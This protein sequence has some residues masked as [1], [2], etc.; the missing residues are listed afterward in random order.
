MLYIFLVIPFI[1][2]V[3]CQMLWNWP[4]FTIDKR[5]CNVNPLIVNNINSDSSSDSS[6]D[7]D[8]DNYNN[9]KKDNVIFEIS[10]DDS[11]K[12]ANSNYYFPYKINGFM[13]YSKTGVK[14]VE[15]F[16]TWLNDTTNVSKN[17]QS[18]PLNTTI[19]N[20]QNDTPINN[21]QPIDFNM[22]NRL[23]ELLHSMYKQDFMWSILS[24]TTT[25][26]LSV[27]FTTPPC[28][29]FDNYYYT[30]NTNETSNADTN[31]DT[32]A[33][34]IID[35][36]SY[37]AIADQWMRLIEGIFVKIVKTDLCIIE[38]LRSKEHKTAFVVNTLIP[39][40][41]KYKDIYTS[42]TIFEFGTP[43]SFYKAI[44]RKMIEFINVH[45]MIEA[46]ILIACIYP[47]LIQED[48]HPA[49]ND[50]TTLHINTSIL[51]LQHHKLY[52]PFVHKLPSRIKY[53]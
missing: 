11:E 23:E 40:L 13:V 37:R 46:M 29:D 39:L 38:Q 47:N 5:K 1:V 44:I 32:N 42:P 36:T 6:S 19:N 7:E 18:E 2:T 53:C 14:N 31:I 16:Y 25:K 24:N 35:T 21:T 3:I 28:F 41:L 20:Q 8:E 15:K 49:I 34:T 51:I 10:D 22:R 50:N 30:N 27:R 43:N 26:P 17:T 9:N 4:F 52:A 33:N 45:G 12:T 48:W